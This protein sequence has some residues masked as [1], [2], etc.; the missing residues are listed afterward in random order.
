[1]VD[2]FN[3]FL[4]VL[5]EFYYNHQ[6]KKKKYVSVEKKNQ[7]FAPNFQLFQSSTYNG[8]LIIHPLMPSGLFSLTVRKSAFLG[9]HRH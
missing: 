6:I 5:L 8:A 9:S 3:F 4:F 7:S 1:M 2:K